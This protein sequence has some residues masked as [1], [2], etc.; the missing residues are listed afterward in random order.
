MRYEWF[1]PPDELIRE[2]TLGWLRVG[3]EALSLLAYVTK[4]NNETDVSDSEEDTDE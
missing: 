3:Y 1:P 4:Q 2:L